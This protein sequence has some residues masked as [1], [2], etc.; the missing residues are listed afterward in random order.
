MCGRAF[1][2]WMQDTIQT[3]GELRELWS[4]VE[5]LL[6]HGEEA[7]HDANDSIVAAFQLTQVHNHLLFISSYCSL[8][9]GLYTYRHQRM[10]HI[11]WW[12]NLPI[13]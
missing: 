6:V 7:V 2:L 8:D 9:V 11:I 13:F 12:K 5:V 10:G 3:V 1:T 4:S